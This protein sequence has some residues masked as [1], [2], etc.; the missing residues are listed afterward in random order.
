MQ[1]LLLPPNLRSASGE[2][3][4]S[5]VS[6]FVREEGIPLYLVPCA[7]IGVELLTAKDHAARRAVLGRRFETLLDDCQGVINT[8]S[9]PTW[10][11]QVP[12]LPD[13]IASARAGF[14]GPAQE[15]FA[16]VLDMLVQS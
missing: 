3:K 2:I 11:N 12:F 6:D 7:V 1:P 15:L 10:A 9:D 16:S 14:T 8:C 13:G 4:R 5:A